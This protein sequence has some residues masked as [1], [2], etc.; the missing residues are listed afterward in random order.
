[1][2]TLAPGVLLKLLDGLNSGVKPTSEHRSSL[3]QVTDIVPA[4]LDDNELWPK[5]G[6]YIKVSDS[7]HSIYVSLPFEQDDLVLSNKM[8]LG[9]FIYVDRLEQGS[10]VPV[11]RG[12]KPLPGRHPLVGTPEPLMGLREKGEKNEQKPNPN[13][14][15][16]RRG[17]WGTGQIGTSPL[18]R[19]PVPLDFDQCT[20]VKDPSCSVKHGGNVPMSP[21]VIRG[22]A[23]GKDESGLRSSVGGALLSK[24]VEAKVESSPALVRKSCATPT[25]LKFPRSRSLGNRGGGSRIIKSPLPSSEKK[26][27][28]PPPNSRNSKMAASPNT[29]ADSQNPLPCPKTCTVLQPQCLDSP[30]DNG[31]LPM[32]LPGKL[33]MLGKEAVQQREKAQKVA[34]QALRDASAT[35][36]L[37]RS[38]K[39][40]SNLSRAAKAEAPAASFDQFLE[41]YE[42]LV[43]AKAEMVSIQAAI[44]ASE[45]AQNPNIEPKGGG[46]K[47]HENNHQPPSVL[48]EMTTEERR[49][50]DSKRR[51]ALYKSIASFPERSDQK[52][53]VL[54]KHLRSNQKSAT[55]E[56]KGTSTPFGKLLQQADSSVENDENK[57]PGG[58][59]ISGLSNTIKLGQ[60]IEDEAGNWFMEFLEKALEK[61]M[62]KPKV[63]QS[64]LLKVINWVEVEQCDSSKRPVHS[65]AANIA[66]KL[67]IKVKN[68]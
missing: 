30:L 8:Q 55:L 28:S 33:S 6:F 43:Q 57:K 22:R 62:K 61:G 42:Q 65:R 51:A 53:S 31:S 68:P 29:C 24:F 18:V 48:H 58:A 45:M 41:F 20:P 17:S 56:R 4:E 3:L 16:P 5:H 19:K 36:N 12:A 64:L 14:S 11:V 63:P 67:R 52:S 50:S 40:F 32:N 10:P 39:M 15:A 38:L 46:E 21:V 7:S 2:A 54:G 25:M 60:Q 47:D 1:M 44:A 23:G 37:V 34:L 66:R 9:Q 35:E 27:C 49:N 13:F 26:S 59:S